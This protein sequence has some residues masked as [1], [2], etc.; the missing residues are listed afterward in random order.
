[1]RVGR[2]L[3]MA[4][5]LAA[6]LVAAP[7]QPVFAKSRAKGKPRALVKD[8]PGAATN[9]AKGANGAAGAVAKAKKSRPVNVAPRGETA[10]ERQLQDDL[11]AGLAERTFAGTRVGVYV[12]DMNTGKV[13]YSYDA[14]EQLNPAS[15]VKLVTT[16]TALD[17]LGPDFTYRTRLVGAA[18][19]ANGVVQGDVWLV[20]TSDPTLAER[21]LAELGTTMRTRGVTRVTGAVVVSSDPNRDVLGRPRLEIAVEA[22]SEEGALPQVHV[23]PESAYVVIENR[24]IVSAAARVSRSCKTRRTGKGKNAKREQICGASRPSQLDVAMKQVDDGPGGP[25]V[26][27]SV[28]GKLRPGTHVS[29]TKYAPHPAVFTGHAMRANL[30]RAGIVVDG[31]VRVD[32]ADATDL[33]VAGAPGAELAELAVHDSIPLG[34]L[35]ARVNKPSNNFLADRVA[36][37]TGGEVFGEPTVGAGV[38]AMNEYMTRLGVTDGSYLLENGSGLSYRNHLSVRQ[39][40]GVLMSGL[41]NDSIGKTFFASMSVGGKDGTLRSRFRARESRGFVFGK[42]GTLTGVAALSGYVTIDGG[43]HVICF[44]IVTN[45]YR[46]SRKPSI[47]AGQARLVDAMYRHLRRTDASRQGAQGAAGVPGVQGV[48]GAADGAEG[49][50]SEADV[51]SDSDEEDGDTGADPVPVSTEGAQGGAGA[52]RAPRVPEV[53]AGPSAAPA[54]SKPAPFA[55]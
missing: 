46:N 43:E 22:G 19:D 5:A 3:A 4:C 2:F 53:P 27:V 37:L 38:R 40:A 29:F 6:L 41:K 39:I 34:E 55:D 7:G 21:D 8:A 32:D 13:L 54:A 12:V 44:A 18:P 45:G 28:S 47:R 36:E 25:H 35:V 24:A 48:Q 9:G 14:D 33:V 11:D 10:S 31:G 26:V 17:A 30:K 42:T 51:D 52:V 1:M 15:N 16:A 50:P 49:A 23:T 20:G